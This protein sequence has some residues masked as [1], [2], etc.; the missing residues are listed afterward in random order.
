MQYRE[1]ELADPHCSRSLTQAHSRA[2]RPLRLFCFLT[3]G[4]GDTR[5]MSSE[6]QGS[7]RTHDHCYIRHGSAGWIAPYAANTHHPFYVPAGLWG[8]QPYWMG[9]GH[10]QQG[11]S[12]W[13]SLECQGSRRLHNRCYIRHGSMGWVA[14]YQIAQQ[15]HP[16]YVPANLWGGGQPYWQGQ[17]HVVQGNTR[18]LGN[19]CRGSHR[20]H[21]HCYIRYG[22]PGWSAPYTPITVRN[23]GYGSSSGNLGYQSSYG[24]T[25]MG[26]T[27]VFKPSCP[28]TSVCRT[29]HRVLI[30]LILFHF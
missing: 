28:S 30:L 24:S 25:S 14:P 8:G 6:C 17:G 12:R 13:M 29:M 22:S 1:V 27:D 11:D 20:N 9:T 3:V 16:H 19:E 7:H 15:V 2:L 21:D 26:C 5:H 23:Y 4:Q 10:I 18:Y